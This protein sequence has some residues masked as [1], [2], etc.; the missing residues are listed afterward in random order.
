[1]ETKKERWSAGMESAQQA[2]QGEPKYSPL[3]VTLL[4]FLLPESNHHTSWSS[5]FDLPEV[6][7]IQKPRARLPHLDFTTVASIVLWDPDHR[8]KPVSAFTQPRPLL[9]TLKVG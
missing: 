8:F 5:A 6:F 3:T 7:L 9:R 4:S 2:G 1:M